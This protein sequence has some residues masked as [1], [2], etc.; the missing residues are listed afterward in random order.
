[1]IALVGLA[2]AHQ[3]HVPSPPGARRDNGQPAA[4]VLHDGDT[5]RGH[6]T[7]RNG[8]RTLQS[9]RTDNAGELRLP[10]QAC[11]GNV[12][13]DR[14][15]FDPALEVMLVA[16]RDKQEQPVFKHGD[17][18]EVNHPPLFVGQDRAGNLTGAET[19]QVV[20]G[21]PVQQ[22]QGIRPGRPHTG[23]RCAP[24]ERRASRRRVKPLFDPARGHRLADHPEKKVPRKSQA[25][26]SLSIYEP[27]QDVSTNRPG[28]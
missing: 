7:S 25:I 6:G 9:A 5:V 16:T 22:V 13:G 24:Q 14:V 19:P 3:I 27:K 15:L 11:Q 2:G 10:A 21:E 23:I 4:T 1:M 20:R 26:S 28:Q 12:L 8:S 18:D 17:R